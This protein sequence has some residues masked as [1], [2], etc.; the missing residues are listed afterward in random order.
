MIKRPLFPILLAAWPT[1]LVFATNAGL[2]GPGELVTPLLAT[3]VG[4]G[5][6]L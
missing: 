2:V 6:L 3:T 1:L 4:F 5:A